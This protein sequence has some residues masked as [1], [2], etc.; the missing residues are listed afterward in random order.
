MKPQNAKFLS[1]PWLL[2]FGKCIVLGFGGSGRWNQHRV[3]IKKVSHPEN[4]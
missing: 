2:E 3:E 1:G 4:G